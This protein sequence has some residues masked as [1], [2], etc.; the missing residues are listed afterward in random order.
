MFW[1]TG[2]PVFI[3][4]VNDP[5][6][7]SLPCP[8]FIITADDALLYLPLD[9]GDINLVKFTF[10]HIQDVKFRMANNCLKLSDVFVFG[11]KIT[12]NSSKQDYCNSLNLGVKS[13]LFHLQSMQDDA[14][15]LTTWADSLCVKCRTEFKVVLF[16]SPTVIGTSDFRTLLTFT[17]PAPVLGL[18]GVGIVFCFISLV[19]GRLLLKLINRALFHLVGSVAH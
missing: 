11:F 7:L 4:L 2:G 12:F 14:A 19:I 1:N 17:V 5:F 6:R 16:L 10:V 9:S 8:F 3:C 18:Q 15:R 13:F